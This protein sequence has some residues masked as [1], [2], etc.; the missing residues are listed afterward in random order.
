MTR[1]TKALVDLDALRKNFRLA[2]ELAPQSRTMA[3]VKANAY[4]HGAVN[5]AWA[6]A[7][8]ASAFGVACIEEALE[9][10]DAGIRHPILVLQGAVD[11]EELEVAARSGVWLVVQNDKQ[12]A[13]LRESPPTRALTVWL[14][15]DTGMHRLGFEPARVEEVRLALEAIPKVEAR[16]LMSHLA[17]ADDL[18]NDF[19][20]TQLE[21]FERLEGSF[22]DGRSLAASAGIMGWPATIREWNRPGYML[23]GNSPFSNPPEG[24]PRLEPVMTLVSGVIALRSIGPGEAV[25][26]AADWVSERPSKIATVA[27]GYGDGYPRLAPSGTPVLVGGRRCPVVGRVSMDMI[28]VDVTDLEHVEIGDE[29]TLWGRGLSV[30]EVAS[31]VGTIGYELLTR[32]PVRTPRVY[33][34]TDEVAS[35][36]QG[37]RS[38]VAGCV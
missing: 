38:V 18:E 33:L 34:A 25:G 8:E 14:M 7:E 24:E 19:T 9:L 13:D 12:V 21:R 20:L 15:V 31:H 32:M 10:R 37:Q 26:Y 6:L 28:C 11:R 30:D 2:R 29:V 5:V 23:F 1:P 22:P 16:V 4:G 27:I 36:G 17:C 3:I 35:R